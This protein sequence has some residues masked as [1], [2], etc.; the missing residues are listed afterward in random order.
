M[1]ESSGVK[2]DQLIERL[3]D[4]GKETVTDEQ[5]AHTLL[6]ISSPA[7]TS[8]SQYVLKK[9]SPVRSEFISTIEEESDQ[10]P[11]RSHKNSSSDTESDQPKDTN[12]EPQT[13][14]NNPMDSDQITQTHDLSG[15]HP[16]DNL[17][18]EFVSTAYPNVQENLKLPTEEPKMTIEHDS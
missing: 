16:Q 10:S 15:D 5:A 18:D 11:E 13:D 9:R 1:N 8:S 12:E 2:N 14:V 6:N 4:K 3:K 17:Q 7:R